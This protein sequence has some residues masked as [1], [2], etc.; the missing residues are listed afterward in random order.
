MTFTKDIIK[1]KLNS[2]LALAMEDLKTKLAYKTIHPTDVDEGA[3]K[4]LEIRK[5]DAKILRAKRAADRAAKM[6]AKQSKLATKKEGYEMDKDHRPV[7]HATKDGAYDAY[8]AQKNEGEEIE[9]VDPHAELKKQ[10]KAAS[11]EQRK[12]MDKNIAKNTNPNGHRDA[13]YKARMAALRK[14][15]MKEG[16]FQD[17]T[18]IAKGVPIHPPGAK[19]K[20][21]DPKHWAHGKTGT[22]TNNRASGQ[23]HHEVHIPGEH[24]ISVRGDHLVK[25]N[26]DISLPKKKITP[27]A[28]LKPAVKNVGGLRSESTMKNS[29]SKRQLRGIVK[30]SHTGD[31]GHRIS[32]VGPGG[33]ESNIKT[34]NWPND[35]K[36][37]VKE[38]LGVHNDMSDGEPSHITNLKVGQKVHIP[39][40]KGASHDVDVGHVHHIEKK[41]IFKKKVGA[42]HVKRGDGSI[43]KHS[44]RDIGTPHPHDESVKE[45]TTPQTIAKEN[46]HNTAPRKPGSK[47]NFK[48]ILSKLRHESSEVHGTD[49]THVKDGRSYQTKAFSSAKLANNFMHDNPK[50]KTLHHNKATDVHHLVHKDEKGKMV[51]GWEEDQYLDENDIKVGDKVKVN[52]PGNEHHGK[53]GKVMGSLTSIKTGKKVVAPEDHHTVRFQRGT[54]RHPAYPLDKDIHKSK[55][56]KENTDCE[57]EDDDKKY[58][59]PDDRSSNR[60][61]IDDNYL[62]RNRTDEKSKK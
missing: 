37:P 7:Y 47:K 14:E 48:G 24:P 49:S 32:D 12:K 18:R 60:E 25:E 61:G 20:I 9:S 43:T 58:M 28:R 3:F 10:Y 21:N 36:E 15:D 46:P 57:Y 52:D 51:E 41:G 62:G 19:V 44:P 42:V 39:A 2:A 8:S 50:Y 22:V 40:A 6:K 16:T 33:K 23:G 26:V 4:E 35:K 27:T 53:T 30:I 54:K 13:I 59:T 34:H 29:L 31:I 45:S 5:Q 11:P 17:K 55:L 38:D 56:V 1:D